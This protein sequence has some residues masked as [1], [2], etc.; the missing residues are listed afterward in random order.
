MQI[1]TVCKRL[2]P[3]DARQCSVDGGSSEAAIVLPP[4]ARIDAY[5]IDRVLGE[6]GMGFVYQATHEELGRRTAIKM[7]RSE[8]ATMPLIV[9]R[10]LNEA[11]AVNLINHQNIIDVYDYGD[12]YG[13]VYFVMEFLE[14]ETL[15]ELMHKRAPMSVPLLLHIFG[16]IA[17]ALAAA[18]AKQIVHRDLKPANVFVVSR[19]DNPRFIKLLDFG[20]AQLRG[21]RA[22]QGLTLA[23][24]VMGT[25]QYMSPEQVS[26]RTVDA[27]SDVWAMGVM[28]YEATTGR[29][30]FHGERFSELADRILHQPVPPADELAAAPAALTQLIARC[31]ER[32]VEDRCPSMA[33]LIDGLERVKQACQLDDD[34]VLAEVVADAGARGAQ[35]PPPGDRGPYDLAASLPEHQGAG[36]D[37][38]HPAR[39]RSHSRLARYAMIGTVIAGL[40]GVGYAALAPARAP[41]AERH[42]ERGTG[43][44][45]PD[46]QLH[47]NGVGPRLA[48]ALAAGDLPRARDVAE[49]S[50]RAAITEG[51]VD[52]RR[53]AVDAL[54]LVRGSRVA[55]LLYLALEVPDVRARAA[56]AL[57]D[58]AVPDAARRLRAALAGARGRLRV[59]IAAALYQLGDRDVRTILLRALE[60][61]SERLLAAIAMAAIGD[62]AGR[63]TLS[64]LVEHTPRHRESW[65]QAAGALVRLGADGPRALLERE[66]TEPDAMRQVGAA[67]VLAGAGDARAKDQLARLAADPAFARRGDAALALARL[68]DRRALDWVSVGLQ[69]PDADDRKHALAVAS[70]LGGASP[71]DA[72]A[73]AVLLTDPDLAVRMTVEA[74]ILGF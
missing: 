23:G 54:A 50:L 9:T 49:R 64:E 7:L 38:V 41:S 39:P 47:V 55:P 18:H 3:T 14:G 56:S 24:S 27:R 52:E 58:L 71:I 25:P 57:V 33:A 11:K 40:V 66:L 12:K 42:D 30:P 74:A 44:V 53:H 43:S 61:P 29:R 13:S 37:A 10:F 21:D 45:Q 28:L 73:I 63:D 62:D 1:C 22:V 36:A 67:A 15:E 2:L 8:L 17:R 4:G 32:R 68:G 6:G 31:L 20:I 60:K 19:E 59:E 26:G 34:A 72:P 70:M 16:Q 69:S 5:R 48:K 35:M 65:R 46:P 51:S